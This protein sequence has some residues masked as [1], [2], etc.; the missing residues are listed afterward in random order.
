MPTSAELIATMARDRLKVAGILDGKH[1]TN[2]QKRAHLWGWILENE[3][4]TG[5]TFLVAMPEIAPYVYIGLTQ[6]V[7]PIPRRGGDRFWGYIKRRYGIEESEEAAKHVLAGF[8]S[9]AVSEGSRVEMRRFAVYRQ[10]AQTVHLSGYNGNQ[11]RIDGSSIMPIANGDDGVFFIDDDGGV[12]CTPEIGPHG[13]LFERMIDPV[14]FADRGL[15]GITAEQMKRMLIIWMFALSFPDIM[16]TKPLLIVE[17][18]PG[19]G[20]SA[21]CQLLQLALMGHRKPIV[22]SRNREDDFPVVLLRSPICVFDNLDSYVDWIPDKVCAYTTLG[23]FPKRKLYT[24]GE[25]YELRPHSFIAVA[26]KNPASFRREDTADRVLIMRL[27]RRDSS[28]L[29]FTPLNVLVEETLAL[30]PQLFGEYLYYVNRIVAE[31]RNGAL[32]APEGETF[33]MADFAS[34]ARAVAKVL[35]WPAEA[36]PELLLAIQSEQTAFFNEADP[37]SDLLGRWL[38]QRQSGKSSVGRL[39]DAF[40]LHKE[41]ESIAQASGIQF[42][43]QA[44]MMQKLRSPHLERDYII[45]T[46]PVDG[47]SK[48]YRFWRKSDPRLTLVP[49]PTQAL[50]NGDDDDSAVEEG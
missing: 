27:E 25:E 17:G 12:P 23:S 4:I 21:F 49:M 20:K 42:Y 26:S 39:I 38:D 10:K 13:I 28:G 47:G 33:R 1:H 43:K 30:R 40:Q 32:V 6:E 5:T 44:N 36:V 35:E 46:L 37:L 14:S 22:L 45:Q 48:A 15:G 34:L 8:R 9:Y 24:D 2:R 18:A 41:L 29:S 50:S 16:P 7:L 19:S 31:I 3:I 11:W